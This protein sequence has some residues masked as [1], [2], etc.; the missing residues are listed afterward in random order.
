MKR[1]T[2]LY[3]SSLLHS[4]SLHVHLQRQHG[5]QKLEPVFDVGADRVVVGNTEGIG[6]ATR[7]SNNDEE[8][9]RVNYTAD[10]LLRQS[11]TYRTSSSER[12]RTV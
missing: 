10:Y 9:D 12:L 7:L 8:N 6:K 3:V 5:C 2:P 11:L 1:G 4:G